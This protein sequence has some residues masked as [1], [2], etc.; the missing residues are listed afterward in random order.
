MDVG[1][2][3]YRLVARWIEQGMPYGSATDPVVTGIKCLPEGRIMDRGTDQQIT[4]MAMYSDGST[5]DVTRMAL[6]EP[7]DPEMAEVSVHGL[8]KTHDLAGEVAI[9]A[10]YQGQVSTFRSTIP[11]G[12]EIA[13][14]VRP[15]RTSSTRPSSA[16]STSSAFP[17]HRPV[18]M[19][20][21]SSAACRSIS[22]GPYRPKAEVAAFLADQDF[23]E[24]RQADRSSARFACLCRLLREQVE[25]GPPQQEAEQ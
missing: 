16:S 21:R 11:L 23:T 3:E 15:K 19:T 8:V 17:P 13:A 6:F 4:V 14:S 9:M 25:H 22:P 12:A 18:P 24:A 5:E 20:P 7:N 2:D 1:S 10:R